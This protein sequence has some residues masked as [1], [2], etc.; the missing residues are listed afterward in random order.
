[1]TGRASHGLTP[2]HIASRLVD[3]A[4]SERAL[5]DAHLDPKA[6]RAYAEQY[7]QELTT[8][9]SADTDD[10]KVQIPGKP[11]LGAFGSRAVLHAARLRRMYLRAC[12]DD[13]HGP[14]ADIHTLFDE[15]SS[16]APTDG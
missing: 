2:A 13:V 6:I 14:F 9:L 8:S 16:V 15:L 5:I 3:A 7:S 11:L 1:M 10:W 4:E 12:A